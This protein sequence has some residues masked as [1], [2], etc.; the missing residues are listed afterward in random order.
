MTAEKAEELGW[1]VE[2]VSLY[3]EEGAEGWHFQ[4][5]EGQEITELGPWTEEPPWPEELLALE[6]TL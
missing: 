1:L 4:G 5:P 2:T 3:D 6:A